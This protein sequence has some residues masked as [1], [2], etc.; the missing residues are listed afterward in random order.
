MTKKI[1][2]IGLTERMGGVETFIYNTTRFSDKTKY[3]YDFLVHGTDHTVFQRDIEKFYN[4]GQNHFYFVP[5]IKKQPLEAYKE[6]DKFYKNNAEKYDYVHLETGAT[7]EIMY[8]YPFVKKYN[9]KV[10]THSHNGNGYS[11]IINSIF[12]PLVN[13]VSVKKLSCSR[14]ATNWLFGSKKSKEVITI[15]NGI[16]TNRFTFNKKARKRIRSKYGILDDTLVIGHIGRFSEQK[17][18]KFILEIF[19]EI[20]RQHNNSVLMLVGVGE[21]E[22]KIKE[23]VT[24]LHLNRKVIFCELQNKTEDFYSSFDI[25]LMPSLYEGLPVVGIEAQCEGLPCFFSN[26]ISSK[27]LITQSAQ[28]ISLEKSPAIWAREILNYRLTSN[29]NRKNGAKEIVDKG[30]S[31]RFTIKQ[32]ENIYSNAGNTNYSV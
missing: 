13:S 20:V 12:R 11:P 19:K 14:E 30:Y 23:Q 24:V 16:D 26:K 32:L 22:N 5:S 21:L 6:L 7:S 17:N 4:D 1:L 15:N 28:C 2:V 3:E 8:V 25:F 9:L 18:H 31:I 29:Y 27:I 10:I